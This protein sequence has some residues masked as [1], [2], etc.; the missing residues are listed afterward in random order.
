M[1]NALVADSD[2]VPQGTA[3]TTTLV[4]HVTDPNVLRFLSEFDDDDA[5]NERALEALKVG[6][7]A[8]M[9][10]SPTLDT[11]VVEAKFADIE[12][13]LM[14][15]VTR[16]ETEVCENLEQ[17]FKEKDGIVPRSLDGFLGE[18]GIM[19]RSIKSYFDPTE[20][21]VC[22]LMQTQIGPTST[23]GKALDP[24]NKDGILSR[25]ECRVQELIDTK[26]DELLKEFSLDEDGSAMCRLHSLVNDNFRR[27]SGSLA[28]KAAAEAEAQ[29]GHIKGISFEDDLYEVF[30]SIGKQLGDQ[31]E[32]VRGKPGKLG[33]SKKGD[34]LATLG[35]DSGA[36]L[37]R[38]AVEL[39]DSAKCLKDAID[40]LAEAR[41]N[42]E[43]ACGIFVFTKG[44]EPPEIG[45]FR[46]IGEDFFCTVDKE[47]LKEGRP[48]IFFDSAVR[49][50][51]AMAI[52]TA[53]KEKSGEADLQSIHD[54]VT[55]LLGWV[56]RIGDMV[57]K[58]S[59][60]QKSG[61]AIEE[62]A[63]MLKKELDERLKA[64]LQLLQR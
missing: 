58:S 64:V 61:K 13:R 18:G 60:V 32:L 35:E 1:P 6:V 55:A 51:R 4:L 25:I 56:D 7:I 19:S 2:A 26:L 12:D 41:A 5:R 37:L 39:K 45:D 34:F 24:A 22:R 29:R 57:T 31:T 33:R 17:Y 40:E 42:R 43:A 62:S 63:L 15:Q 3:A 9:S 52:A 36:P 14:E 38:I 10:A 44:T 47:A 16:F 53:K 28:G 49:I 54:H 20:G 8:I 48:L 59:T 30:A 50:A 27:L 46:K 21:Q 11:E 23:F